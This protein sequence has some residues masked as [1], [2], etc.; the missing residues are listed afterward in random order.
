MMPSMTV[1][2]RY[3][4]DGYL[5][6]VPAL[7]PAE[8]AAFRSKLEAFE[9]AEPERAPAI[10]RH[11]GHV[12]LAWL[13]ELVRHPR[14]LDP[15]A[16]ILGPDLLCWT[17]NAFIKNPGDGGFVTWHQDATYWGLSS[18]E[19]VTAWIALSPSTPDNG[20]MRVVPGSHTAE[21]M[22]HKDTFD[23]RNLLT[24]GQEVAVEVDEGEAVDLVLEAGQ[25]SLH[26]VLIVHGS[27]PAARGDR[28]IGIAVR[29]VPTS[30]RQTSG[31]RDT[32]TLVRGE[33]RY[34]HFD[35]EPAPKADLDAAAMAA[36]D[37]VLA[38]SKALL[39]RETDGES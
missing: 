21:Q 17:S 9:E 2:E 22:P 30:I 8:A 18:D 19:V 23:A 34:G 15:V 3:A 37:E 5:S 38:A 31:M 20:C 39:Y 13:S 29:Y 6:P 11:K 26:H 12:V 10:L 27:A 24:R 1:T 28:R 33:D 7:T 35:L 16:E 32:A 4:K 25:M 36:Y 14:V